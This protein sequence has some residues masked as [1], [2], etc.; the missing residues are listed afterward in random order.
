MNIEQ[1][2]FKRSI[3]VSDKLL[4]FGF[5]KKHDLYVYS[6]K[7]MNDKF[8][9]IVTIKDEI[10]KGKIYDLTTNEEY[11]NY[12]IEDFGAFS[13]TVRNFY[14]E[15][16][17]NIRNNCFVSKYFTSN[18]A[19][20]I[21]NL[22]IQNFHCEPEFL[23]ENNPNFGVFRCY[24]SEKW[25]AIIMNIDK[26]KII[27]TG[28]INDS[29]LPEYYSNAL[30]FIFPSLYEGFGLPVL[31][32]MKCGCPVI[33]SDRSSLPEVLGDCGILVNPESDEEMVS[34]FEKMYYDTDFRGKC[35]KNGLNRASEFT[36]EKCA[37]ELL[38][39]IKEKAV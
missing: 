21:A 1:E 33:S 19:N 4:D 23:W 36:W 25:F 13:N 15:V 20:R 31:E 2:L 3:L 27:I 38:E 17:K 35:I 30:M 32:A 9:V 37:S 28:Y 16:L 18:Q 24:P 7:I 10:I 11:T 6:T 29:E 12:R 22:I 8:K 5:T 26:S 39:F 14:V 34:A